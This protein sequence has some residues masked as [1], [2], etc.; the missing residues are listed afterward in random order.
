MNET[1][2]LQQ[3]A[4]IAAQGYIDANKR[5]KEGIEKVKAKRQ[6][7]TAKPYRQE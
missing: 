6:E 7:Q 3:T 5:L 2:G 1:K 4:R